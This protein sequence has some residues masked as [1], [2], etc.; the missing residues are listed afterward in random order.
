[1]I[2][3]TDVYKVERAFAE[4][5]TLWLLLDQLAHA[6]QV[7]K[8][9]I[10]MRNRFVLRIRSK[11][12]VVRNIGISEYDFK[13]IAG[14]SA[15]SI[16]IGDGTIEVYPTTKTVL[17]S[18]ANLLDKD[19]LPIGRLL[20]EVVK[21]EELGWKLLVAKENRDGRTNDGRD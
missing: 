21:C 10:V 11:R 16:G 5:I 4:E 9:T 17:A 2:V 12:L 14:E 8:I 1:M 19:N 6:G 13:R 20:P 18:H 7:E 3:H 15:Y